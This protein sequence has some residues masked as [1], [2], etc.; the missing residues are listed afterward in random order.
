M[1]VERTLPVGHQYTPYNTPYH[2]VQLSVALLKATLHEIGP[3]NYPFRYYDDFDKSK[4]AIDT[5]YNKEA[6]I[7]GN[8]PT[9]AIARGALSSNPTVLGDRGH[10]SMFQDKAIKTNIV[11]SSV[12]YRVVCRT[13][14][15]AEMLSNEIYNFLVACR[16]R[17]PEIMGLV[18]VTGI[19]LSPVQQSEQDDKIYLSTA[20]FNFV[21]QYRWIEA[22]KDDIIKSFH[23]FLR[24]QESDKEREIY[25]EVKEE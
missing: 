18:Q 4:V 22:K 1:P 8:K 23:L 10:E 24:C 14:A 3:D 7:I 2:V 19:N 16:T 25:N 17:F 5:V 12:D 20:Q 13:H 15:E 6:R 21:M 9:I 11:Q